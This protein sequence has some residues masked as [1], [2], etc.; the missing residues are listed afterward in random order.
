MIWDAALNID[1]KTG[2]VV[3][4]TPREEKKVTIDFSETD[5]Q[6]QEQEEHLL[7]QK[8]IRKTGEN[9]LTG[10]VSK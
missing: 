5:K 10:A 8:T 2:E 6:A 7:S 9:Y 3:V 1:N 4:T